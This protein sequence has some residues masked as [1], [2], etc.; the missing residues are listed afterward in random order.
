MILAIGAVEGFMS[1]VEELEDLN[2]YSV[3]MLELPA[4]ETAK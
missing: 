4:R 1:V 3:E 2:K